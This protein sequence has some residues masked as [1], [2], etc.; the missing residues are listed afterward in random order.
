MRCAHSPPGSVGGWGVIVD[1]TPQ[2]PP[3]RGGEFGLLIPL[4]VQ[5]GARG[6]LSKRTGI[7]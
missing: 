3:Q 5:E 1:T 2:S 6:W 7:E 4:L